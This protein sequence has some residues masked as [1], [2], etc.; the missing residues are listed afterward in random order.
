MSKL[1]SQIISQTNVLSQNVIINY[2]FSEMQ[3]RSSDLVLTKL[4]A[5]YGFQSDNTAG[6]VLTCEFGIVAKPLAVGTPVLADF[7]NEKYMIGKTHRRCTAYRHDANNQYTQDVAHLEIDLKI[8][9]PI[10]WQVWISILEGAA[11]GIGRFLIQ[12]RLFWALI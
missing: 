6:V 2:S 4:I 10:D 8:K 3:H 12:A 5:D 11:I 1:V 9:I 7:S